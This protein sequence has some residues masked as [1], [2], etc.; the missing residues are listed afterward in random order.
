LRRV[1][2]DPLKER[3]TSDKILARHLRALLRLDPRLVPVNKIAGV[4]PPRS[5]TPGFAGLARIICGQQ[6]SVASA[7][8]I[9]TRLQERSGG[10]VTADRFLSLGEK[11]LQGVGLSGSKHRTLAG[12]AAAVVAGDLDFAAVERLS[13][14]EAIAALVVHKGIGPWTAEIYLMFCAGH[15]DIFPAGDLALQKAVGDAFGIDPY[16]DRHALMTIAADWAPHRAT[17]ALLFWRFYRA[18]RDR[19]GQPV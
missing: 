2:G 11:G 13:A 1:T 3:L 18:K 14:E 4:F 8:A 10:T 5:V 19:E 17:A 15:P 16:P 6:L 7:N 9:W 12:I